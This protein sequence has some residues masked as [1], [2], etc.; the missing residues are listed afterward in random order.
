MLSFISFLAFTA[1]VGFYSWYRVRKDRFDTSERYFLGGRSLTGIMIAGSMLMTNISTEHLIGMNGSSY[2]NG[3]VIMAWEVTSALALIAG[4]VFFI[5]KYL[6]MGITT[7]PEFLESRYDAVTRTLVALFLVFSFVITVLPIV[8]YTGAIHLESIFNISGMLGVGH[9]EGLWITVAMIGIIGSAYAI[10]GGLKAVA[11]SDTIQGY[12]LWIGG[13]LVPLFALFQIGDGNLIDGLSKVFHH[14]PEKFNA[15]GASDSVLPFSTLFTGLVINQIYFWCMNQSI[16]QRALGAKNLVEAQKG[17]LLTGAM[18]ILM[19]AIIVLPGVIGFYY[20]GDSLYDRQD[21]VYPELV[22]KVLP[23]GLTG[24]FAAVVM[25]AV[26]STF[27]GVLNSAATLF[28]IDVYKRHLKKNAPE[29]SVVLVGRTVSTLVAFFAILTAPLVARAPQGLYQLL[30]QL[31]G[32]F[33]IPI[34]SIILAGFFFRKI[35]SAGAKT[36]LITGMAFYVLST[37]VLKTRIH[38]VHV[39]GI[40]FLLNMGI[41]FLVS[42]YFPDRKPHELKLEEKIDL[43]H[44]KYTR[45]VSAIL[46]F[47]TILA[48][49][50]LSNILIE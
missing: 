17:L 20:F 18:K 38:F 4:A 5:P 23:L 43:H 44:W 27:N 40:E 28:S 13:L 12:G 1:F 31:N 37:F 26:L 2:R 3:F 34:A 39:W 42:H 46:V 45:I 21:S 50:L 11:V 15:I 48:Y 32:I 35:S 25:G 9:S 36:A 33:F 6:R 24:L 29:R 41:M 49:I 16:I 10:L 30:Q 7:I 14:A 47:I 19:P 22:K 8:L